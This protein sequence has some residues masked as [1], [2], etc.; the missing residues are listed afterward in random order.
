[1]Q[2]QINKK[3]KFREGFR[4][5]APAV[6]LD[7]ASN[8]FDLDCPSPYMTLVAGVKKQNEPGLVGTVAERQG[9]EKLGFVKS[10]IP[11]ATHVDGSSRLQTVDKVQNP[12]FYGLIDR[13]FQKTGC[14]I[15]INTSFNIRGEPIVCSPADSFKCFMET[16][17]DI[18]VMD[19]FLI[20]KSDK[21]FF[22]N[23]G[24]CDSK[25]NS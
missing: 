17:M 23:N 16:E 14:P 25:Q 12:L 20:T 9:F 4:P 7:Q 18:L 3:I 15:L 24:I 5:F 8:W 10:P 11:A 2:H 6:L 1:M 13:F 19:R 21:R 22:S